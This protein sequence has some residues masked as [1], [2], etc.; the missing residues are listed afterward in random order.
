M[1]QI[2]FYYRG[3]NDENKKPGERQLETGTE[4][5]IVEMRHEQGM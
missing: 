1:Y 2:P 5:Y 4:E 3:L